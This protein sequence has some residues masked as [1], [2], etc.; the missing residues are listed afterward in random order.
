MLLQLAPQ[1]FFNRQ[2][3]CFL[4]DLDFQ[5]CKIG[6]LVDQREYLVQFSLFSQLYSRFAKVVCDGFRLLKLTLHFFV[7]NFEDVVFIKKHFYVF[8]L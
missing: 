6:F 1:S 7:L 5:A 2:I 8:G 3:Q 4:F